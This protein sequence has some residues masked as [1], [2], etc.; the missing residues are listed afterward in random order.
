MQQLDIEVD[1]DYLSKPENLEVNTA[2]LE[3]THKNNV[4]NR[5]SPINTP[6]KE[7]LNTK[8]WMQVIDKLKDYGVEKIT[9]T[10]GEPTVREDFY[11]ILGYAINTIGDV[12]V[13]TNGTTNTKLST[14]RCTVAIEILDPRSYYH[15]QI[16]RQT[17]P[18]E[19]AY[20]KQ[21]D[22]L[23][24][25]SGGKCMYCG[26]S[27]SDKNGCR[28]HLKS[29]HMQRVIK[30]LNDQLGA[31]I[32]D[33][34][35]AKGEIRGN[36]DLGFDFYI[37]R[38]YDADDKENALQKAYQKAEKIDRPTI[39][40]STI[41][42]NND[43]EGVMSI[44][45]TLGASTVFT[46]LKPVGRAEENFLDQV[47]SPGRM[48]DVMEAVDAFNSILSTSHTINSPVYKAYQLKKERSNLE[49]SNDRRSI[50]Q[51]YHVED[52]LEDA[53][54][55]GRLD[56]VG[57]SKFNVLPNGDVTPTHH[58]RDSKLGNVA[59]NTV[60][61]VVNGMADWNNQLKSD[62]W[63][64]P[65]EGLDLRTKH[66]ASDLDVVLNYPYKKA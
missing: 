8:E 59:D 22:T 7:E 41:M 31:D 19:F 50:R 51:L 55:R 66:I 12:T 4:F 30:D 48:K 57:I 13:Q 26:Q 24:A 61:E 54:K 62:K 17:D 58:L 10:G 60:E 65:A 42:E 25:K 44:A 33:W 14:Y 21:Q 39:I 6:V 5:Q 43:V 34:E 18:R 46:P 40:K 23:I 3:L 38:K 64:R 63:R 53:W 11:D 49:R 29:A 9:L 36:S 32:Q 52:Q 16:M 56:N 45:E 35:E 2:T 28:M 1:E 15:N 27:I 47:P 37:E 20:R